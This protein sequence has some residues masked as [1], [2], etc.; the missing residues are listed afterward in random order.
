M[1]DDKEG[2]ASKN[3]C[4]QTVVLEKTLDSPLDYKEIKPVNLKGNQ[5]WIFIG[6]TDFEAESPI[7]WP[8]DAKRQLTRKDGDA[9][10]NWGQEEKRM[11][12]HEVVGW[13]HWLNGHEF[14]QTLGDGERQGNLACSSS[15]DCKESDRTE[16]LNNNK[17]SFNYIFDLYLFFKI[18]FY[19]YLNLFILIGD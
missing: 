1:L 3:W 12:E 15:W 8:P 18:L 11:T 14:E 19:N 13:Y 10:N 5:S 17:N 16:Q 9:G 7:P 2:W 6:R 4:F